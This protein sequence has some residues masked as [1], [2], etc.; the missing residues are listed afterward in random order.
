MG[1]SFPR[2]FRILC[3]VPAELAGGPVGLKGG[4]SGMGHPGAA[5]SEAAMPQRRRLQAS[6][7]APRL[8]ETT[9]PAASRALELDKGHWLLIA[10]LSTA[11]GL[12]DEVGA[13][14]CALVAGV[15]LS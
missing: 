2:A 12:A 4:A 15:S 9:L 6:V 14:W 1:G 8:P 7:Q 11:L 5:L 13:P 10:A 3:A